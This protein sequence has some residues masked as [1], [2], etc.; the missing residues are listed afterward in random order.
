[1]E[2]LTG[3]I[4]YNAIQSAYQH[5]TKKTATYEKSIIIGRIAKQADSSINV[6]TDLLFEGG[7]SKTSTAEFEQLFAMVA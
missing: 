3:L 2:K 1:M 5:G 4:I 7:Y 6:V